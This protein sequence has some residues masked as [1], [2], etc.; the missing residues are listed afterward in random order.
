M[1]PLDAVAFLARSEHRVAV[2]K[3]LAES[4]HSRRKL[5]AKTDASR[6]TLSR[7]LNAFEERGWIELVREDDTW[8]YTLTTAGSLVLDR[9]LPLLE[10]VAGVE[11]LGEGLDYLPVEEMDI[12]IRHFADADVVT[13]TEFDPTAAVECAIQRLRESGHVRCVTRM[14]PPPYVRAL[15]EAVVDGPSTAE[16]VLDEAYV[17]LVLESKLAPLW[18]GLAAEGDVFCYPEYVPH[19]LFALEDIVHLWLSSDDG[20]QA[21][22]VES[23]N[24]RVRE[25]ADRVTEQYCTTAERLEPDMFSHQ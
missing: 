10:T 13:A 5:E 17:D 22:V 19:R 23:H 20:E 1:E 8:V 21:G 12:D 2:L 6:S 15:H 7:A 16:L 25:W 9:F 11:T 4:S 14:V 18:E 24:Q 3:A